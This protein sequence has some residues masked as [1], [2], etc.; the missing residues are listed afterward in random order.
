MS[1]IFGFFFKKSS[2]IFFELFGKPN[3]NSTK[4]QILFSFCNKLFN[5]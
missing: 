3:K 4:F 1:F 2:I 5:I